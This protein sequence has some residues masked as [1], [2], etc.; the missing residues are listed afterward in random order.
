[1]PVALE[2]DPFRTVFGTRRGVRHLH[3]LL[4]HHEDVVQEELR[5]LDKMLAGG[6]FE[7]ILDILT[8]MREHLRKSPALQVLVARTAKRAA[9][10]LVSQRGVNGLYGQLQMQKPGV[11][12]LK[13]YK[14][15]LKG[16][17]RPLL[18]EG[19]VSQASL[20]ESGQALYLRV[21]ADTMAN[22][23]FVSDNPRG[24]IIL[25]IGQQ[26]YDDV[27]RR[28]REEAEVDLD[29]GSLTIL[30]RDSWTDVLEAAL[31]RPEADGLAPRIRCRHNFEE[32]LVARLLELHGVA[33]GPWGQEDWRQRLTKKSVL[34]GVVA[35]HGKH[36]I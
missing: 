17:L 26:G 29:E 36:G 31:T 20:M 21:V 16:M 4:S 10:S 30:T 22:S 18:E 33:P 25:V 9:S 23:H 8:Q 24:L 13:G 11:S 32:V 6:E 27:C 7:P 14:Y 1:M 28:I 12:A 34:P 2:D 5:R 15:R 35:L 3:P 19:C